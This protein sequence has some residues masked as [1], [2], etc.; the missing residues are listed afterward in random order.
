MMRRW[1]LTGLL[2]AAAGQ[3]GSAA[4]IQGKGR[5][6]QWLLER[7]WQRSQ[8]ETAPV[9]PWPGART[10]PLARLEVPALG[11]RRLVV[12]GIDTPNL[13]W[14]PGALRGPSGHVVM[15]GHRDT[16]FGFL[17]RLRP[18]HAIDL[19]WHDGTQ[20]RW[21]VES[22]RVVDARETML[23]PGAPGPLLTLVTCY[24]IDAA[25]AGGPERLVITARPV[26]DRSAAAVRRPARLARWA[27]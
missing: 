21:R 9:R 25:G 6:G 17:G 4:W 11:V 1:I 3:L 15:A 20:R 5:L 16:H 18:G 22:L 27:A 14:G 23:D 13:A 19:T 12:R 8:D 24:P 2:V 7:A 26:R 10:R